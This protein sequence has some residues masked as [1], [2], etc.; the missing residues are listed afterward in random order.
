[1][2]HTSNGVSLM[3]FKR[4]LRL[5]LAWIKRTV[6]KT[7][8]PEANSNADSNME[9]PCLSF[10]SN[11]QPRFDTRGSLCDSEPGGSAFLAHFGFNSIV[12]RF[13]LGLALDIVEGSFLCHEHREV[14]PSFKGFLEFPIHGPGFIATNLPLLL[15]FEPNG[16]KSAVAR[17]TANPT[18]KIPAA[19]NNC[20]IRSPNFQGK[21]SDF[22]TSSLCALQIQV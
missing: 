22:R 9:L 2:L 21:V 13:E 6:G 4:F 18:T 15:L 8:S 11:D 5:C 16:V 7:A 10:V 17:P 3:S 12:R 19:I 14:F 20:V 1:M